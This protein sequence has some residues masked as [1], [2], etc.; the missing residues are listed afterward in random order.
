MLLLFWKLAGVSVGQINRIVGYHGID[1]PPR[2]FCSGESGLTIINPFLRIPDVTPE[3]VF[4]ITHTA[5]TSSCWF[6]DEVLIGTQDR[7]YRTPWSVV[8]SHGCSP[9]SPVD[10]TQSTY[11]SYSTASGLPSD[12]V[13]QINAWNNYLGILTDQGLYWED[14]GTG[15]YLTCLTNSGNDVFISPGPNTYLAEGNQVN[16]KYGV[17]AN[18][19]SWDETILVNSAINQIWVSTRNSQD[20]LFIATASGL[21]VKSGNHLEHPNHPNETNRQLLAGRDAFTPPPTLDSGRHGRR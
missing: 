10:I 17:P 16:I 20:T 6:Q 7:V 11:S 12:N 13:L 3:C 4:T 5:C 8:K 2:Y 14:R 18:F 21:I 19:N 15:S 1:C 9:M